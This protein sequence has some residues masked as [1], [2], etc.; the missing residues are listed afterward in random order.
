MRLINAKFD[1]KCAKCR[2]AIA[3]G[4]P[5]WY[6]AKGARG[7]KAWHL[8][9]GA[10]SQ[11]KPPTPADVSQR[12]PSARV[13]PR[14]GL[15]ER[16]FESISEYMDLRPSSHNA[17]FWRNYTGYG[18]SIKWF[19]IDGGIGVT[20]KTIRVGWEDGLRKVEESMR[21]ITVPPSTGLRR[22]TVRGDHGDELDIHRV[23]NGQFDTAWTRRA[24]RNAAFGHAQKTIFVPLS[25][26]SVID[27]SVLFWRGA[28]AVILAD[29][30]VANGYSVE[31]VGMCAS[32]SIDMGNRF[33]VSDTFIIKS[34]DMPLDRTELATAACLAGFYRIHGFKAWV[35]HDFKVRNSLGVASTQCPPRYKNHDT[36]LGLS[37]VHSQA[38][39][40]QFIDKCVQSLTHEDQQAA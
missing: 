40:Q 25:V 6:D 20:L 18:Q 8:A 32:N 37:D 12:A 34:H 7:Q 21:S 19:G 17:D 29:A 5:I 2:G 10:A 24:R 1:G 36:I 35:S 11:D 9:C 23:N 15:I 26:N 22:R 33:D 28:A 31:I 3:Q 39:A 4:D 30:L 38:Q 13:A 14:D 27:S 16:H